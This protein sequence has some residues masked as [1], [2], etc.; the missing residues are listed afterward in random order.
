MA[1]T[2]LPP[3]AV[4]LAELLEREPE[5]FRGI[6][7]HRTMLWNFKTGRR[8]PDAVNAKLLEDASEGR[9]PANGW[10]TQAELEERAK[11]TTDAA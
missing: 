2:E 8:K 3:S 9:V 11:P 1:T 7:I 5:R 6:G 10:A 4:A